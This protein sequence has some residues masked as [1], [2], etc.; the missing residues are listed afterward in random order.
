[1]SNPQGGTGGV[2]ANETLPPSGPK[3]GKGKCPPMSKKPTKEE[4]GI[5]ANITIESW[6]AFNIANEFKYSTMF[7]SYIC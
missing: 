6:A 1:M 3:E 5:P 2:P 7:K 4:G